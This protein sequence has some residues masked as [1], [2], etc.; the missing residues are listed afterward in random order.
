E[1]WLSEGAP[2]RLT[3]LSA[4]QEEAGRPPRGFRGR[5]QGARPADLPWPEPPVVPPPSPE[6]S[7]ALDARQRL[8]AEL[9]TG[10]ESGTPRWIA[11]ELLE[12]HRREARPAWWA[13]FDRLGKSPDELLEDSEAIA[14]LV[15]DSHAP[16]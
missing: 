12:Y 15:P 9:V 3:E 2:A 10:A 1:R 13:Y 6:S 5:L 14:Y 7:E 11:G 4:Q 16:P 8:R